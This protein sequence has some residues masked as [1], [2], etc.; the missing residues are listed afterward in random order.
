VDPEVAPTEPGSP[1]AA[2][3]S[4]PLIG[5]LED[6]SPAGVLQVLSS[7]GETGAV[8]FN[9]E[10]GCTVYLHEGQLY[11]AETT[12][13]GEALAIAL[14]RPGRLSPDDWDNA[15]A[16]GYPT[17]EVGQEL[18]NTGAID[19]EL[20]ASVVLSVIYDPLIHLFRQ[21]EGDFE[22]EPGTVHWM[23]PFRTFAV[24][25]I[26]SEVR[27]RVREADEMAPLI[28]TLDVWVESAR[29][30]P[31]DRGTVNLRRDDWEIVVAAA[32]GRSLPDLAVELGRGTWSTARLVYRLASVHL[33]EITAAPPE[34]FVAADETVVAEPATSGIGAATTA[35][36]D[37]PTFLGDPPEA[38]TEE[39]P[40]PS[41]FAAAPPLE[42]EDFLP[43]REEVAEP[44]EPETLDRADTADAEDEDET[45]AA[46]AEDVVDLSAPIGADEGPPALIDWDAPS[47][48]AGTA[49]DGDGWSNTSWD[50]QP[51]D[52]PSSTPEGG[53]WD[54]PPPPAAPDATPSW[55][56]DS[57]WETSWD[58]PAADGMSDE[59]VGEDTGATA[60]VAEAPAPP[61]DPSAPDDHGI[62]FDAPT[63]HPDIAKALAESTYADS[64]TAINAMAARLG[65]GAD[66]DEADDDWDAAPVAHAG[67]NGADEFDQFWAGDGE[68]RAFP[69]ES[70]APV[71]DGED[72]WGSS[73]GESE[74]VGL[75][76]QPTSWDTG[77]ET[78]PLPQRDR[79][80]PEGEDG[81]GPG[82]AADP[83]WLENLYSQFMANGEAPAGTKR[84]GKEANPVEAAFAADPTSLPKT[85][86]LRRVIDAIRRL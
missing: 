71:A 75:S 86:P 54:A 36:A 76:W 18:I 3:A 13:T 63:L 60:F 80:R 28:P 48:G 85:K 58:Q 44:A 23:G 38:D 79:V 62:T 14:V 61:A 83:E 20:L 66:A 33:L 31:A 4:Q 22:F 84:R 27:R 34:P 39:P 74:D 57:S 16:A 72:A 53:Q 25:A 46:P 77:V 1:A 2:D 82:G 42:Q 43:A 9:G 17:Q 26:V 78:A 12:D 70:D 40:A 19:R 11:F 73:S 5:T 41:D 81:P 65:A 8:R 59:A 35:F 32:G 37:T 30:L 7:Q 52:A 47:D 67:E 50:D 49:T 69:W 10:G 56:D 55:S 21:G 64:A 15:T 6:Y 45:A 29:S 51:W 24:D 68:D